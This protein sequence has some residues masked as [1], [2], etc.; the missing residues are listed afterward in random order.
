MKAYILTYVLIT[1]Q[2]VLPS[3]NLVIILLLILFLCNDIETNPG[4]ESNREISLFHLNSRSVRNKISY[5]ECLAHEYQ[6]ISITETHLDANYET[7]NLTID[8]F[9]E[10][11]RLDRNSHGGGVMVYVSNEIHFNRRR[12]LEFNQGEV[13]WLELVTDKSTILL[14]T[15]Y[16]PPGISSVRFWN[17]F[18]NSIDSAFSISTNV[19]I[20]GDT[21]VDFLTVTNSKLHDITMLFNLDNVITEPTRITVN[22]STL[23]DLVLVSD[24]IKVIESSVLPVDDEISD[25]SATVAVIEL[26]Q[27]ISCALTRNVWI[28]KDA[29]FILF[30]NLIRDYPWNVVLTA[31]STLDESCELF[32]SKFLEFAKSSI[33]IKQVTIRKNDKP[34]FTS[35]LRLEIR[36]RNRLHAVFRKNKSNSNLENFK[37]QRNKVNNMKKHAKLSFYANVNG[38][39]DLLD[40]SDSKSYWRLMRRLIGKSANS[41]PIPALYDPVSNSLVHDDKSKANVLNNYFCSIAN[42]DDDLDSPSFPSRCNSSLS[43][44]TITKTDILDILKCLKL[45]KATGIDTISHNMLKNTAETVC[46]PLLILFKRSLREC[47]FPSAWKLATVLPLFKKNESFLPSNYRPISLLSSVGK[48]FERIVHKYLHNYLIDNNLLYK[49]Q[50]GFVKGHSTVYQL[51]EI[52]HNIC[53]SL[54]NKQQTCMTFFDISKA[55]DRVWHRGLLIKLY[56]YGIK[57]NI[58]SW[59]KNYLLDRKQQVILGNSTSSI[60]YLKAGVPQGSVLGPLL[61]LIFINDIT[62]NL[63]SLTRMFADDTSLSFSSDNNIEIEQVMNYDLALIEE[64]SNK[65]KVTFNPSKTD[66]VLFHCSNNP[67][68]I[69]LMFNNTPLQTS[70]NH[71]HLGVTLN[72]NCKWT[73]HVNNIIKSASRH[74]SVLRKL[75]FTLNRDTLS[76]LYIVFIRPLMEYACELWDECNVTNSDKLEKLQLEVARIVTGLPIFTSRQSLYYET[77]WETLSNRRKF[78]KL[79]LLY[80][81]HNNL[82]PSYLHDIMPNPVHTV[83]NYNLR[84]QE[85]YTIPRIRL[86]LFERSFIPDTI[87]HWNN[88]DTDTR[89]SNTISTFKRKISFQGECAPKF[90]SSGCRKLNMLHTR[91]RYRCS[92]LNAD[93]KRINLIPSPQCICSYAIEDVEHYLLNCPL[94]DISRN[95]FKHKLANDLNLTE[96]SVDLLLFGS[97]ALSYNENCSLFL[98]VQDFI[99]HTKRFN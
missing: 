58:L 28:Y 12:D 42:I 37:A 80:K 84:N 6:V 3:T 92:S 75:K 78:R 88:L 8:G 39:I 85:N 68:N 76:K 64:W 30:N 56:A 49:Y 89:S 17:D 97:E 14:C 1:L 13:I 83:S 71:K 40:A 2:S 36:K 65:W 63:L 4:P 98:L 99:S 81:I 22:T 67:F 77:G 10:P 93:L 29:N 5:V 43:S 91:L 7:S 94:F 34:W 20:Q 53:S 57:G 9:H 47:K 87:K 26:P 46:E 15:I 48:L 82:T 16:R 59:V 62:D 31:A 45:N 60:G 32:T 70:A 55:F 69:S 18:Q 11:V 73:D 90:Y 44:I 24:N 35:E 41:G 23:I 72:E 54:E 21:N 79:T 96:L 50:S 33:P 19:V 52:Y 66:V 74:I 86:S 51:I 27:K 95:A 61:F 38:L 25:H